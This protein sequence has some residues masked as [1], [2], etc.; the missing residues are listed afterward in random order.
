M[1]TKS[2]CIFSAQ[3]PPHVGGVETF[4]KNL[5]G[6]LVGSGCSV[7]VVTN[8][9][10][11][12]PGREQDGLVEVVRLPCFA[13]MNGRMPLPKHGTKRSELLT[14]LYQKHFDGV[15]V[16]TRFY[17]H[18]L[19]GMKVACKHGVAP[20][21][22]DHGSAYLTFGNAALDWFEHIYERAVTAWGKHRFKPDYYGISAKSADW[23]Q[24]FGIHACGVISNAIDANAYRKQTSGRDFVSELKIS[25]DSL[26]VAFVGRL[27]PEKGIGSL[28]DAARQLKTQGADVEF[29]LAGT[30]PLEKLVTPEDTNIHLLGRLD[31]PD[32][33]ALLMQADVLCLPSRSEGF[34]T[35]LLEAAACATSAVTTDVGGA[36]ELI[37]DDS[38]GSI[39]SSADPTAITSALLSHS[40][41]EWHEMGKFCQ[42]RVSLNNAWDNTAHALITAF[43]NAH[44]HEVLS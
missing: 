10:N 19:L 1:S 21:V 39:I 33:A 25:K 16:N 20:I 2:I 38:Y 36:R 29:L 44:Q 6:T 18:S 27:I 14:Y 37:P 4:T 7:T 17:L 5:A 41:D 8:A 15:L 23:L 26:L 9:L 22:L 42:E 24:T 43:D 13:P 34:A 30:G 28:V 40:K 11:H 32:V 31:Q 3:Y 12:E 35:C